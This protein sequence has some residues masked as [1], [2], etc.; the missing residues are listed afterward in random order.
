MSGTVVTTWDELTPGCVLPEVV[1]DVSEQT[2]ILVPVAT[3]D[4]FPG[5]HSPR[6]A[7]SQGQPDMYL[8]TI[9]L[10]GV[11]D[12]TAT[13]ALGPATF[14]ARRTLR[15]LGSVHPGD[16]LSGHATVSEV[17][18]DPQRP[19]GPLEADLSVRLSTGRG[20]AV[21]ASLTVRSRFDP[22][23]PPAARAPEA[24]D[25]EDTDDE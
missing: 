22:S 3:W 2:V 12:R 14:V 10:Q 20:V 13:D 4:L 17:R 8:N 11:V 6:Y 5:H 7:R 1:L 19:G 9:A 21:E 15:M 23:P 25:S 16:R 18:H 24:T